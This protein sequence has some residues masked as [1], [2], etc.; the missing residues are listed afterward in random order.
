[1]NSFFVAIFD[2]GYAIVPVLLMAMTRLRPAAIAGLGV[3]AFVVEWGAAFHAAQGGAGDSR[4]LEALFFTGVV[5]LIFYGG[6][7]AFG[8]LVGVGVRH[9]LRGRRG[10]RGA[11]A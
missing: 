1:M 8:M 9:L 2:L 6:L 10:V 11:S 4:G 7:W 3:I 5:G